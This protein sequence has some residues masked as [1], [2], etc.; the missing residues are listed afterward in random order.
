LPVNQ[1]QV[2]AGTWSLAGQWVA[3]TGRLATLSRHDACQ[4]VRRHGGLISLRVSQR[5]NVLVVG[6]YGWPLSAGGRLT[7]NLRR[8][9]RLLRQGA[10]LTILDEHELLARLGCS[11]ASSESGRRYSLVEL[12]QIVDVGAAQVRTWI[13]QGMLTASQTID[14]LPWF[15]YCQLSAARLL[16]RLHDKRLKPNRIRRS[17]KQLARLMPQKA[18][19]ARLLLDRLVD[20]QMVWRTEEGGLV[21]VCGQRHF[22][23]TDDVAQSPIPFEPPLDAYERG[24]D[25]EE[26]GR[27][28]LA[29]SYYRQ[30][31]THDPHR[32]DVYFNLGN[33]LIA[34]CRYEEA[35]TAFHEALR[36]A[37]PFAEV[38][39]NLGVALAESGRLQEACRAFR[40]ALRLNPNYADA[41]YNLADALDLLGRPADARRHWER[42]LGAGQDGRWSDFARLRL[43]EQDETI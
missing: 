24:C 14:G 29:E 28:R 10:K 8:A 9:H 17:L 15:D 32:A 26:Q 5:T 38:W 30:A 16:A 31:L 39:N 6:Q 13:E 21:D 25:A 22:D 43:A 1:G 40:H 18:P 37:E 23:F 34:Q 4:L 42:Y 36:L 7:S 12:C 11:L 3:F 27:H 33:V 2:T 41:H 20:G 19:A 35:A